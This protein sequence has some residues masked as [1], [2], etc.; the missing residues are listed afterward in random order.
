MN[1]SLGQNPCLVG[2]YLVSECLNYSAPF[3]FFV[4]CSGMTSFL[5]ALTI[6][7]FTSTPYTG[8]N[9]DTANDCLCSTVTYSM[10][11]ACG[12]C[13][14]NTAERQVISSMSFCTKCLYYRSWSV[15]SYNCSQS[16]KHLSVSVCRVIYTAGSLSTLRRAD[17]Q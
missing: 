17:F 16:L 12:I 11:G 5:I 7:P 10:F 1:N 2:S 9:L 8:P 6:D 13:Q 15:W 14:N 3:R 4:G